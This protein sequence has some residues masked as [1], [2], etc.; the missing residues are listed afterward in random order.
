M[1]WEELGRFRQVLLILLA[2]M[3]A[4]FLLTYILVTAKPGIEYHDRFLLQTEEGGNALYSGKVQMKD[5]VFT[6]TPEG[7]VTLRVGENTFGPYTV[8]K[9]PTVEFTKKPADTG[10]IIYEGDRQIFRGA[11][12]FFQGIS[13]FEEAPDKPWDR[14]SP[15]YFKGDSSFG[16]PAWDP[17][18]GLI[19]RMALGET[20]VTHRGNWE[21]YW[22]GL[23][24]S[25]AAALLMIY[26]EGLFRFDLRFRIKD[27]EKAEPSDWELMGRYFGWVV[28]TLFALGVY[29]TGLS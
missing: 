18:F 19:V 1:K 2:V 5:T 8:E 9:D 29:I 3:A 22:V 23:V 13:F 21:F 28:M 7:Q 6:V 10:L 15:I 25:A 26:A 20:P 17:P 4:G 14:Y 27:P 12:G 16:T 11:Y 24:F